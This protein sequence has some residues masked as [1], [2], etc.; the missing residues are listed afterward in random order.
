M[1]HT[2]RFDISRRLHGG[3]HVL[4][5]HRRRL[6]LL[7]GRVLGLRLGG[8]DGDLRI[9]LRLHGRARFRLHGNLLEGLRFRV[10]LLRLRCRVRA[11]WLR[12]S[13]RLHSGAHSPRPGGLNDMLRLTGSLR[14]CANDLRL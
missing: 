5:L 13:L 12:G 4:R 2:L 14:P 11:L 6:L 9:H 1:P 8:I 7:Q 3:R 10:G